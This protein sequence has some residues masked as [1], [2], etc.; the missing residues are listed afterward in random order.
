MTGNSLVLWIFG[1]TRSLRCGTNLLVM[2]LALTDLLMVVTQ[3]PVLVTNCYS[4]R[5]TLGPT[6]CEVS[7]TRSTGEFTHSS[8]P[9]TSFA[10]FPQRSGS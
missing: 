8:C 3:F 1:T 4:H 7:T 5:W 2:N 9:R 6:A 10:R